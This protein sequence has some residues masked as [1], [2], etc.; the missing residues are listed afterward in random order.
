[1]IMIMCNCA[2]GQFGLSFEFGA[3]VGDT[4]VR[5]V[6]DGAVNIFLPSFNFYQRF[7]SSLSVQ[8]IA[9]KL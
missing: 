7:S 1:M 8:F 2:V 4:S 5:P 6:F 3:A 9:V